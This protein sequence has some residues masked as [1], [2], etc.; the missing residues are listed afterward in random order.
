MYYASMFMVIAASV[1]Y[2][3]CQNSINENVNPLIS[4]IATYTV[5]LILSLVAVA[6]IPNKNMIASFKELNWASYVL[7]F[8]IF[9]LEMG[10]LLVYRSGWTIN[11]AALFANVATT[12]ILILLGMFIF[13]QQLSLT[14]I[15]GILLSVAGLII[16]KK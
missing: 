11:I 5:A 14:N 3:L 13:K 7:G 4:M 16:M 12:I 1:L 10:F 6:F 2:N 15:I 9:L 8:A